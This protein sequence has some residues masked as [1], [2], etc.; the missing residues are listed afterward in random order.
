M[1]EMDLSGLACPEPVVIARK[2]LLEGERELKVRVD[3]AVASENVSRMARRMG[4]EVRVEEADGVFNLDIRASGETMPEKKATATT[5]IIS[6]DYMGKGDEELGKVL[7]K[8]FL[9]VLAE[10]ETPPER[11]LLFNTGVRLV[12]EDAETLPALRNLISSG[13]EILVCGTCLDFL[14]LR[15]KVAVGT[16]SNMYEIAEAMSSSSN[17]I[18]I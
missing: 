12:V 7:I 1:K 2:A 14:E 18:S 8:T 9:N 10:A 11:L 3:D 4:C 15:E 5:F 6:A 13:S 16:V 17:T